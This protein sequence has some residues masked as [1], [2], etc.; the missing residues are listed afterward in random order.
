MGVSHDQIRSTRVV[1]LVGLMGSG[2][3]SVGRRLAQ[4]MRLDFYDT[5]E[6]VASATK[7]SVRELFA[8]GESVFRSHERDALVDALERASKGSGVVATGG[9]VVTV[10]QN[11]ADIQ[12]HA[13]AVV[14]LDADVEELV[15]RTSS[16]THRPL[17]DGGAR[18]KLE[19]MHRER[20][21]L[22]ESLATLRVSTKGRSIASITELIATQLGS[23]A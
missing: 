8:E 11:V 1:V 20:R 23:V 12:R 19:E 17:L 9:G 14:W 13:S 21:S 4:S 6:M 2:K 22:Y 15:A 3:S 10:P 18:G 7:K 16:G 5:D